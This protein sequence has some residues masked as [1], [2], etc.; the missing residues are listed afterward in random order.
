[1]IFLIIAFSEAKVVIIICSDKT[2]VTQNDEDDITH[3]INLLLGDKGIILWWKGNKTSHLE[4]K[5]SKRASYFNRSKSLPDD[6]A[7]KR[8]MEFSERQI[9][10]EASTLLLK[11]RLRHGTIS[12]LNEDVE[13]RLEGWVAPKEIE[14]SLKKKWSSTADAE[15]LIYLENETEKGLVTLVKK[16]PR[17]VQLTDSLRDV[18]QNISE[19]ASAAGCLFLPFSKN[20]RGSSSSNDM[21]LD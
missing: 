8:S 20:R 21:E 5:N 19:T 15:L 6:G 16:G 7:A 9:N 14:D 17:I 2:K 13:E 3:R 10:P 4:V 12:Y 11:T 1:M 18:W